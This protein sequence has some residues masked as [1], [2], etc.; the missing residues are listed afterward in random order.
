MPCALQLVAP[1]NGL[2]HIV[3]GAR[4]RSIRAFWRALWTLPGG[5]HV[6]RRL[7]SAREEEMSPRAA[8]RDTATC[9]YLE[10]SVTQQ[11]A[12]APT[13]APAEPRMTQT[14]PASRWSRSCRAAAS[15]ATPPSRAEPSRGWGRRVAF[16]HARLA[17]RLPPAAPATQRRRA[18]GAR[19]E[20]LVVGD[21]QA[22]G[23]NVAVEHHPFDARPL[24]RAGASATRASLGDWCGA[25]AWVRLLARR[26]RAYLLRRRRPAPCRRHDGSYMRSRRSASPSE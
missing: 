21:R 22:L 6:W 11:S 16:C 8:A 17:R 10:T 4:T 1:S 19:N 20:G 13:A 23:V 5:H 18:H 24:G 9:S 15:S 26:R 2:S 7:L 3:R 12:A 25:G 14:T